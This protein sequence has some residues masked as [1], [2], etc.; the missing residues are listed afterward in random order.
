MR[1]MTFCGELWGATEK[2]S[3]GADLI[4]MGQSGEDLRKMANYGEQL[5]KAGWGREELERRACTVD[6]PQRSPMPC[7]CPVVMDGARET[8]PR[9]TG[10]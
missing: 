1:E 3:N 7:A 5:G 9:P 4:E 6:C 2:M 10:R 8:E